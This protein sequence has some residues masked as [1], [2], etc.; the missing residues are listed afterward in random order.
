VPFSSFVRM[1]IALSEY[2][3]LACQMCRRPSE[4]RFMDAGFCKRC[5]REAV[6]LGMEY[7]SFSG[8]EPFVHPDFVDLLAYALSLGAKVQLVSN[9]T[10]IRDKHLELLERSTPS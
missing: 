1:D 8:G 5:M 10:L 4:A 9:G 2:C 6:D 3:N 7:L